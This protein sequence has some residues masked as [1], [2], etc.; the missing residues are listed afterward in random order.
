[1][2]ISSTTYR[3]QYTAN[4]SNTVFAYTFKIFAEG[5]I[6][7]L[8]DGVLKTI[9]THY[10]V[11]GVGSGSGGNITFLTAPSNG[12][13]VTIRRNEPLTQEIDY[14]ENDD[15]P[16]VAHEEGLD[17]S[18]IRDQTLQEQIDR[19]VKVADGSA[20]TELTFADPTGN[21][22]YF[23]RVNATEDGYDY[24]SVVSSGSLVVSPFI[25][26]L[27]DDTTAAAARTTLGVTSVPFTAASSST[28]AYL[29]LA[30]DTDNG[31]N[32]VRLIAPTS[33]A[34]DYTVTLPSA[35]GTLLTS[36]FNVVRRQVFTAT[37]TYTPHANMLYCDI[38]VWGGG[39]GGGGVTNVGGASGGGG[40]AG[41]YARK[42][43]SAA[44]IGA[45]QSVTIGAGGTAGANTGGT[46]GT[47]GTTSVGTIVSA[48]GGSGGSGSTSGTTVSGGDGGLGSSGD[49]N[50]RGQAGG[51][52]QDNGA[53]NRSTGFGGSTSLGGG[54]KGIAMPASAGNAGTA[55]SGGGGSGAG[56]NSN[57]AFAGGA[58]GS[59]Y[60]VIT[61]FCSA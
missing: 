2:T 49:I 15:F 19:C 3:N 51:I 22:G 61:E 56:T 23:L 14:V 50:V 17:R 37:G 20:V 24:Q 30:E 11:S 39:G 6:A 34:A 32:R 46:G 44:T 29:D 10:T 28:S 59:G 18:V 40:G 9:T 5:D 13:V 12:A 26:T 4:G 31:T 48:T 41:G 21:A 33:L 16:A 55:N 7:V 52:G 53:T 35:T 42:V 58:G 43:V 1:M 25:E 45:S 38:E 60:V 47:G 8:V 57:G 54:G 36:A 27:L